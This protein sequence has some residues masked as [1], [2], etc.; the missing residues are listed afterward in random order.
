MTH[1][2]PYCDQR[3]LEDET[4]CWQC[5]RQVEPPTTPQQ[6]AVRERW[7][8]EKSTFSLSAVTIYSAL[9]ALIISG[10]LLATIYLGKQPR[11]QAGA[12]VELPEGWLWVNESSNDFLLFLPESWRLIDPESERGEA[13][14]EA[15]I[16]SHPKWRRVMQPFGRL[17]EGLSYVFLAEGQVPPEATNSVDA[18]VVVAQSRLLNQ[19]SPAEIVSLAED[20]AAENEITLIE[21]ER[22]AA[23]PGIEEE[24]V[25]LVVETEDPAGTGESLRCQQRLIPG[26]LDLFLVSS[27]SRPESQYQATIRQITDSFQRLTP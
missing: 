11:L 8:Q 12:N 26:Q 20:L 2:C 5:G 23:L 7:Q 14:L 24:Y 19:L 21:N 13:S 18:A 27:C 6:P 1:R 3:L 9:T 16:A 15:S 25:A 10:A 22:I 4:V 17:D